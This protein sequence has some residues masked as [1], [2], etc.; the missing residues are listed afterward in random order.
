MD[1]QSC[2]LTA[3]VTLTIAQ[4]SAKDPI[5]GV[6]ADNWLAHAKQVTAPREACERYGEV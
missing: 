1:E 3:L 4:P 6:V 2:S 5:P